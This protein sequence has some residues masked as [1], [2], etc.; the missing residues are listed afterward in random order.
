M[1]I[2][3]LENKR[4]ELNSFIDDLKKRKSESPKNK[5]G[6]KTERKTPLLLS[7]NL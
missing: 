7:V 1:L 5:S 2:A 6:I 4:E 3:E